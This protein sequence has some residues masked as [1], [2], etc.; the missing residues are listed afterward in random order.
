MSVDQASP[1][2]S[3]IIPTLNRGRY[4][5]RAVYSA[6]A[7]ETD[8]HSVEIIVL[9][10]ESDDG[11]WEEL[12]ENFDSD[13]RVK[14]HQNQ[15]GSGPTRS[16]LDGARLASGRYITFVWSD[17]WIFPMFLETLL[18]PLQAGA[19]MSVGAGIVRDI[20]C[21]ELPTPPPF[22]ARPVERHAVA[23]AFMGSPLGELAPAPVS[24]TCALFSREAFDEWLTCAEREARSTELRNWL[25]WRCAI[26]PDLLLFLVACEF[27]GTHQGWTDSAVAQFSEHAGSITV[28]TN[29]WLLSTGYWLAITASIRR[30]TATRYLPIA[31]RARVLVRHAAKGL[32]RIR[33]IP[34][35]VPLQ[36]TRRS[37]RRALISEIV[38]LILVAPR[39]LLSGERA[40][41]HVEVTSGTTRQASPT[42]HVD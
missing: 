36:M 28:S 38:D 1:L 9:D 40:V 25:M 37:I 11:S 20:D 24:P 7:T 5:S 31:T 41:S 10:S 23:A 4:V 34:S 19:A 14:L 33:R 16:W 2:V 17:D 13:P 21:E 29:K 35:G 22:P 32:L 18:P 27:G 15:R 12:V 39:I 8:S 30:G 26:G 42:R 3:F 6:L